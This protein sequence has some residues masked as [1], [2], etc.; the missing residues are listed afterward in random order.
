MATNKYEEQRAKMCVRNIAEE[1]ERDI[2][3]AQTKRN[4]ENDIS[5]PF[6]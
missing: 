4:D 6:G 5:T 1:T 3:R 2:K